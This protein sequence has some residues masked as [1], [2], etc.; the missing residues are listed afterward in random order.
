MWLLDRSSDV[1]C[2]LDLSAAATCRLG[3]SANCLASFLY[4]VTL[5][6]TIRA[7]LA[8]FRVIYVAIVQARPGAVCCV[9]LKLLKSSCKPAAA[10]LSGVLTNCSCCSSNTLRDLDLTLTPV[11][12]LYHLEAVQ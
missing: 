3:P 5:Q 2:L 10:N 8:G 1:N 9:S 12:A 6:S 7:Y 4:K 11:P